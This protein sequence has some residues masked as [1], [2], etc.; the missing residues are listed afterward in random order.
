MNEPLIEVLR[1]NSAQD[2]G[3]KHNKGLQSI[4]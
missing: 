4:L 1:W 2:R 3:Y